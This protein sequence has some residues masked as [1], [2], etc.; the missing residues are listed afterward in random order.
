MFGTLVRGGRNFASRAPLRSASL[1]SLPSTDHS[2]EHRNDYDPP[3]TISGSVSGVTDAQIVK[4]EERFQSMRK[5]HHALK[6]DFP[7]HSNGGIEMEEAVDSHHAF[8]KRLIYRSK[9][10]GW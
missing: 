6:T 3:P 4:I 1:S 2:P 7:S 8:R 9:Q 10:R 5:E